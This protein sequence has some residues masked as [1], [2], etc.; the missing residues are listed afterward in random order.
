M[1]DKS[2]VAVVPLS[3]ESNPT[4]SSDNNVKQEDISDKSIHDPSPVSKLD[5]MRARMT[6]LLLY[7]VSTA[8]FLDIGKQPTCHFLQLLFSPCCR[9]DGASPLPI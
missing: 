6:P 1:T 4:P 3:K 8:Q 9:A 7:V 2:T 5:K